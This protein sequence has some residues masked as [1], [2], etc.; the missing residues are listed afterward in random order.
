MNSMMMK[1]EKIKKEGKKPNKSNSIFDNINSKYILIL[2]FDFLKKNKSLKIMKYNNEIKNR[3]DQTLIDY[4]NYSQIKIEVT[5]EPNKFGKFININN[6]EEEYYYIYFNDNQERITKNCI[7]SLDKVSKIKIIILFQ[8]KSF[9]GLFEDCEC[10][11][12]VK[13][14]HFYRTNITNMSRM[15]FWCTSL[16]EVNLSSF[17]TDNV[18]DMSCMFV[19]CSQLKKVNFSIINTNNVIDMSCMFSGCS[20]LRELDLSNLM[21]N[22]VNNMNS[23]FVGCSSLRELDISNFNTNKVTNMIDMFNGCSYKLKKKIMIQNPSIR[24]IA[25]K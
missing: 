4:I 23:M 19:G 11:Q 16:K 6:D 24:E 18:T 14:I 13:F 12:T 20:S 8:V 22:N 10:I 25:F 5:P 21:T 9:C 17:T 1:K 2:I 3:T 15:F 7:T